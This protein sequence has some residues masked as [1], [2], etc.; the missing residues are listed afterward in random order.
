MYAFGSIWAAYAAYYL[1]RINLSGSQAVLEQRLGFTKE[2]LGSMI[3]LF[4]IVY[5]AGQLVNGAMCDRFGARVMLTLGLA[6]SAAVNVAISFAQGAA[7]VRWL[8]MLNGA[9]QSMGF[10]ACVK[11][12]AAW[13]PVR[14]R[15]RVAGW[16]SLSYYL[17]SV[18]ALGLTG[19]L[20]SYDWRWAF[21]APGL[22]VVLAAVHTM[23]R[24]EESPGCRAEASHAG[25]SPPRAALRDSW[26]WALHCGRLWGVAFAC[27]SVAVGVYG[28][29]NWLP[30]Y[31]T[32]LSASSLAG[33][34]RASLFSVGSCAGALGLGWLSDRVLRGR[35]GPAISAALAAGGAATFAFMWLPSHAPALLPALV[36]ACGALISGGHAHIVSSLAMDV[37]A[38][39]AAGTATGVIDAS[40]Y[41]GA[42]LSGVLTGAL[43]DHW[44]WPSAFA[45]WGAGVLVGA[46][47]I[48]LLSPHLSHGSES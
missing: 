30:H 16:F 5:G 47:A 4:S 46:A 26:R 35:R 1:C 38:G 48:A 29:A 22:L 40:G 42:A 45:L 14:Q 37:G 24:L 11:T 6:G 19:W 36:L 15:G 18:A 43:V 9:F 20:V 41:L 2:Q 17:G 10:S 13:F 27:F 34:L 3:T 25:A 44:G 12:M 23:W 8:W 21:R 7:A 33:N 31:L 39:G 32:E 28:F